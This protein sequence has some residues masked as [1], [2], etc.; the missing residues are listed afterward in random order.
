MEATRQDPQ[1]AR[2]EL[3][4]QRSCD[5]CIILS[6]SR[7]VNENLNPEPALP[8][9]VGKT[10]S[11]MQEAASARAPQGHGAIRSQTRSIAGSSSFE[12][13]PSDRPRRSQRVAA[14]RLEL[15]PSSWTPESHE[16]AIRLCHGEA[17][18]EVVHG[19]VQGGR[20]RARTQ[21]RRPR[22]ARSSRSCGGVKTLEMKREVPKK[23]LWA[24]LAGLPALSPRA[25]QRLEHHTRFSAGVTEISMDL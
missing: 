12:V 8:G 3:R 19:G 22:I 11:P 1:H 20:G 4:A 14:P 5:A 13:G 16:S 2:I 21:G 9:P 7:S 23:R 6:S 25:R 17:E 10:P 24:Q 18:A 15:A